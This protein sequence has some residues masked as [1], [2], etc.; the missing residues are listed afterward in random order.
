MTAAQRLAATVGM[1][2]LAG[3]SAHTSTSP[4]SSP[5]ATVQKIPLE[6]E[7]ARITLSQ[8]ASDRLGI[9]LATVEK[10]PVQRRRVLGGEA[11]IPSGKSIIVS[12]PVA[13]T[14]AAP[15]TGDIPLPGHAVQAGDPVLALKPLLS[16]ERYV[17]TPAER[18][19]MAN[20]R[21]TLLSALTLAQGNVDRGQAE[22][23]AAVIALDRAKQLF[24]DKAGSQKAVDDAQALM[25]VAQSALRAAQQQVQQFE[26]LLKELEANEAKGNAAELRMS[27]PQSGVIRSLAVTP[28][29]TVTIGS[30]LFEVADISS[31]WVRVPVYVDLL[32]EIDLQ[33]EVNIGRLNGRAGIAPRLAR[34]VIAP[35]T[36]DPLNATADLYFEVDN[37]DGTL[38]PGQRVGV[39]LSLSDDEQSIVVPSKAILY[40]IHGGTWVY[41]QVGEH[42]FQRQ[43]VLIQS[44]DG[45]RSVLSEG[46]AP[47]SL[48][49][50]DGAAELYGTEF[51]AGK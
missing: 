12:A 45:D 42:A 38:R 32:A 33:S 17:P 22:V 19:Q 27:T 37:Q 34:P 2:L 26:M 35:P 24:A 9:T 44:T 5:P 40:D 16:P 6:T 47:Q 3:C 4:T 46:P 48:V 8:Q 10:Q 49:V 13:G 30:P 1:L 15:A 18:V 36:A 20:A 43:R 50:V 23:N 29:Q 11:M 7:I 31:M 41:V 14:I 25:N 51:G 28:G 39:Q 21:A